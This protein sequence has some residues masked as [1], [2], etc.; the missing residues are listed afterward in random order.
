MGLC[1]IH[2]IRITSYN[3]CYTKLL[4]IQ[5]GAV[6]HTL[7]NKSVVEIGDNVTVG[8]NAII[9]GAKIHKNVL[10]G[11]GAILL[12]FAEVGENS[13]IAAG[14]I[15]FVITSYSIHYTKLYEAA[16]PYNSGGFPGVAVTRRGLVP[17]LCYIPRKWIDTWSGCSATQH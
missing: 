12:D 17:A 2:S 10:I 15:L 16:T 14:A 11:M 1:F 3:V 4:R 9:H 6:L 13:I 7:Y 5:D 8:H